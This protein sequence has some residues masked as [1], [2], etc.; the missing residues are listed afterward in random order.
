MSTQN[1][2][3]LVPYESNPFPQTHP[4]RLAVIGTLLGMRPALADRSRV[5]EIGCASGGNLIPLALV[6]PEST[7][8]GIDL[9]QV[10][11][12][13]GQETIRAIGL[14]N[15]ELRRMS[16]LDFPGPPR[17]YEPHPVGPASRAGREVPLGSRHLLFDYII[18]HG[19]FSW[20]PANVQ[21]RIFDICKKHLAPHGIAY[22]SYNTYPGWHMRGMIRDMLQY[23]ASQFTTPAM[24]VKQARNLLDF[25]GKAVSQPKT[26]TD[27]GSQGGQS[28]V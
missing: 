20:V 24:K 8:L 19:V 15:I 23:H 22:I 14:T 27:P 3:D 9:S 10:Q 6:Y 17:G 4:D 13:A 2:Y 12:D 5:L 28:P 7:F 18:C 16:I 21:E 26:G 25:L 11:I 1:S